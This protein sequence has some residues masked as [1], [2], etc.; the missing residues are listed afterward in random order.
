MDRETLMKMDP[1]MLLSIVN[2]KLRDQFNS[3]GAF[4]DD[5]HLAIAESTVGY[6]AIITNLNECSRLRNIVA[7]AN[8]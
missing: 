4:C 7:H 5:F 6:Q 3:L 8:W 1:N 2:M